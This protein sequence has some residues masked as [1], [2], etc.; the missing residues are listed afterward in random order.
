MTE[1]GSI[2]RPKKIAPTRAKRSGKS[3]AKKRTAP[4]SR[5]SASL[6]S[7]AR[8]S[9]SAT[10]PAVVSAEIDQS[11]A[12][13]DHRPDGVRQDREVGASEDE[14][15]GRVGALEERRQIVLRRGAR[16]GRIGPSLLGQRHEHLARLL[17]HFRIAHQVANG[18]GIGAA[19]DRALGRDHGDA[20][21]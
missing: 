19:P 14:R 7:P 17:H 18:A 15:V 12:P 5:A 11:H 16:R 20:A 6:A 3:V 4:A 21:V 13:A 1:A 9:A 8:E 10:A 2:A